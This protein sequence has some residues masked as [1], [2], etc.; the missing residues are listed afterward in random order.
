MRAIIV[1]EAVPD[2]TGFPPSI[3]LI[4]STCSAWASRSRA[5]LRTSSG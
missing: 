1:P 5:F 3:P 2:L 4:F